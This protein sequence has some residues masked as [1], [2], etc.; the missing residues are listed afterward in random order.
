MNVETI[1]QQHAQVKTCIDDDA[2]TM[3]IP[4]IAC[5]MYK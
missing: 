5:T 1:V 4:R 2:F 3:H